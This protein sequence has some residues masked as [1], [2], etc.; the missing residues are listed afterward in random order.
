MARRDPL[1]IRLI[2]WTP[3][4]RQDVGTGSPVLTWVRLVVLEMG[5]GGAEWTSGLSRTFVRG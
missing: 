5:E 1:G 2:K 4:E 3:S